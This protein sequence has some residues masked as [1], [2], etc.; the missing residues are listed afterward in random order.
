V[1][2]AA[3]GQV[4]TAILAARPDLVEQSGREARALAR[5]AGGRMAR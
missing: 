4:G 5:K 3:Q 1:T 2:T